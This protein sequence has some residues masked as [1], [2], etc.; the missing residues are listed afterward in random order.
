MHNHFVKSKPCKN[1]GEW[2]LE[3]GKKFSLEEKMKSLYEY[4]KKSEKIPK[5]EKEYL[6]KNLWS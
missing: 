4:I 6:L 2:V 5:E 1:C 3:E